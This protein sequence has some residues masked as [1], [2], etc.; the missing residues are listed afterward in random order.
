LLSEKREALALKRRKAI[1]Q[2]AQ[3]KGYKY[4]SKKL[5]V[6]VWTVREWMRAYKAGAYKPNAKKFWDFSLEEREHRRNMMIS[7]S[8]T[9]S[10]SIRQIAEMNCCSDKTVRR[11]L[12]EYKQRMAA[13]NDSPKDNN[14]N[15]SE[16]SD[17]NQAC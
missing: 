2:F 14:E 13:Q 9:G 4:V 11:V 5:E 8:R 7:L 6:N 3:G 10:Y 15:F 16:A 1:R 12:N 17:G